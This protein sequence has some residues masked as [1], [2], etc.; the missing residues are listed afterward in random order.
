MGE[1]ALKQHIWLALGSR[2]ELGKYAVR[3]R[4]AAADRRGQLVRFGD[5]PS[6]ADITGILP[7]GRRVELEVKTAVGRLTEG[8]RDFGAMI[9]ANKGVWAVVRSADEA[10]AVVEAALAGRSA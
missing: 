9:L 4:G 10:I 7:D 6:A 1:T 8:Q 3:N 2:P 5:F